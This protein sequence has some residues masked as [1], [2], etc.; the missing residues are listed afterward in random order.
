MSSRL[1][2]ELHDAL[3]KAFPQAKITTMDPLQDGY[4][5][6]VTIIDA[7][8]KGLPLVQRHRKVYEA[9]SP[10]MMSNIHAL[11]L[12]TLSPEEKSS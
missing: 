12:Q 1:Q 6:N 4:H 9:I 11:S 3:S 2:Q 8:F 10:S 5:L 7:A